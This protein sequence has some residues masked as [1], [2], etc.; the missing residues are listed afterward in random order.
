MKALLICPSS[1]PEVNELARTAPLA[2]TPLLGESLVEYWLT[3]LALSGAKEVRILA[4]DRPEYIR[5]I[6]GK[7]ERWGL[8]ADVVAESRELTPAQ[9]QIKHTDFFPAGETTTP[10]F[11]LDHFPGT[12]QLLFA[13]YAKLYAA[14]IRWMPHALTADRVGVHEIRPGVW[15]HRQA[16][17]S[18]GAKIKG[19]CWIG[20]RAYIGPGAVLGPGTVVEDRAFV[21]GGAE[22]VRSIV[23]AD[24][25]VGRPAALQSSFAWGGILVNWKTGSCA[26][27]SDAFLLCGLRRPPIAQSPHG[28][29]ARWLEFLFPEP[30]PEPMP[31]EATLTNKERLT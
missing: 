2:A 21:E 11:V 20:Q 22:I 5:A 31:L 27:I 9:A 28:L 18:R 6:V 10:V 1:R 8:R 13:S 14:L 16:R 24:T 12:P 19:P 30:E 26:E 17:I 25:F 29:L 4:D 23:G 3:N 15:V 7:G